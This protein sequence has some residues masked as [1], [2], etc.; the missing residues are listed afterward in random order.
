MKIGVQVGA[1]VGHVLPGPALSRLDQENDHQKQGNTCHD[2]QAQTHIAQEHEHGDQ[3]QVENLQD[4]VDDAVGKS[5]GNGVHIVD[6]TGQDLA[7]RPVVIELERQFLQMLEQVLPDV[8]DDLLAHHDHIPGTGAGKQHRSHNGH[9]HDRRQ[10]EQLA[11]ILIGH[12]HI[13]GP[14]DQHGSHQRTGRG[15]RGKSQGQ[16]HLFL[17]AANINSR[18]QQMFYIKWGFKGFVNIK[19]V[20]CHL[21]HLLF[22]FHAILQQEN[23]PVVA[24]GTT[25]H[26][27]PHPQFHLYPAPRSYPPA[28]WWKYA[29]QQ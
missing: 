29:G 16:N 20:A 11:I 28:L 4:K 1:L 26:G 14:L 22:L 17:V 3:H 9:Q 15:N 10:K 23:F 5:I 2:D 27:C 25:P 6:H 21:D 8:V 7:V 12:G 13:D 24:A 18:P 19:L